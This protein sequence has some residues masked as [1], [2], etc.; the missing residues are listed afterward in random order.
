[1]DSAFDILA[2]TVGCVLVEALLVRLDNTELKPI[3]GIQVI[4]FACHKVPVGV[5]LD[6]LA[7]RVLGTEPKGLVL[8]EL[9]ESIPE[10]AVVGECDRCD[11]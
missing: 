3:D 6:H 4:G 10:H 8:C 7:E 2:D 9:N 1:M 5:I 11:I